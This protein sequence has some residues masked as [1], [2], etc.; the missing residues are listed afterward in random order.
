MSVHT[1]LKRPEGVGDVFHPQHVGFQYVCSVILPVSLNRLVRV[2]AARFR[3]Q[4]QRVRKCTKYQAGLDGH[5]PHSMVQGCPFLDWDTPVPCRKGAW[6]E[7]CEGQGCLHEFNDSGYALHP[8]PNL[9]C[10][11]LVFL[12]GGS[13]SRPHK[14]CYCRNLPGHLIHDFHCTRENIP[15]AKRQVPQQVW[16]HCEWNHQACRECRGC[17]RPIRSPQRHGERSRVGGVCRGQAVQGPHHK[18]HGRR[19]EDN[20]YEAT[21]ERPEKGPC[22]DHCGEYRN[23]PKRSRQIGVEHQE[24]EGENHRPHVAERP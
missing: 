4:G 21:I 24:G 13:V 16:R 3:P 15:G 9:V 23:F 11:N 12:H 17:Q 2:L 10:Q 19:S 14:S 8:L 6:L 7:S 5:L 1:V 18:A 22:E 20:R